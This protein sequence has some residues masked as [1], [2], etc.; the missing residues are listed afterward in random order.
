MTCQELEGVRLSGEGSKEGEETGARMS[1]WNV[2]TVRPGDEMNWF[3]LHHFY[4]AAQSVTNLHFTSVISKES[5][6][7][8]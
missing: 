1:V 2:A 7:A 5:F 8:S 6:S 3:P 4:M